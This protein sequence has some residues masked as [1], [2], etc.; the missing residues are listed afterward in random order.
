MRTIIQEAGDGI[1]RAGSS[2][3]IF[4]DRVYHHAFRITLPSLDVNDREPGLDTSYSRRGFIHQ[5]DSNE[6]GSMEV[7]VSINRSIGHN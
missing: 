1:Y 5:V 7:R 3:S 6:P 4:L 2:L